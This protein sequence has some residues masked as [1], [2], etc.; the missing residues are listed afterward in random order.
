MRQQ[1][2]N[3]TLL[4]GLCAAAAVVS[5]GFAASAHAAMIT[6][7]AVSAT[8]WYDDGSI[9]LPPENL[10]NGSNFNDTGNPLTST[11]GNGQLADGMWSAA[12]GQGASGPAVVDAQEVIFDLGGA[13]DLAGAYIWQKNQTFVGVPTLTRGVNELEILVSADGGINFASIGLFNLVIAGGTSTEPVQVKT[14]ASV[15]LG[16]THVK[17]NINSALSGNANEY[18]GLSEVRFAP[19]PLPPAGIAFLTALGALGG[20]R[21]LRGRTKNVVRD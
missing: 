8:S 3:D 15:A 14:F 18:V 9:D 4:R 12:S 13:Y 7:T 21:R 5:V 17:F 10:I 1:K 19:V 20:M 2:K 11:H 6:P 16:V